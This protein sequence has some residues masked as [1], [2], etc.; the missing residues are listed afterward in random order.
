MIQSTIV[1]L[2]L[3]ISLTMLAAPA[4]G[5]NPT[6]TAKATDTGTIP[7]ADEPLYQQRG[8][9]QRGGRGGRGGQRPGGA[10]GEDG[11]RQRGGPNPYYQARALIEAGQCGEAIPILYCIAP[12]DQGYEVVQYDLAR[13]LVEVAQA[14]PDEESRRMTHASALYWARRAA[15]RGHADSQGWLA[16][17]YIAGR[18]I[19]RNPVEAG[20]WYRVFEDNPVRRNLGFGN[21]PE[22]TDKLLDT[23]LSSQEWQEAERLAS[24]WQRELDSPNVPLE[25]RGEADCSRIRGGSGRG[26]GGANPQLLDLDELE[27]EVNAEPEAE[28]DEAT[29]PAEPAEPETAQ[30]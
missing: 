16:Y 23:N 14:D 22:G 3:C 25:F 2:A 17:Q 26:T 28:A 1:K 8:G 21:A 7:N 11:G 13:C 4:V 10:D 24:S 19:H 6:G 15:S 5:A 29:E 30:N 18:I 27:A 12:R 9:G 20:K